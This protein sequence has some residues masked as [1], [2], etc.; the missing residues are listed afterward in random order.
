[1]GLT[2]AILVHCQVTLTDLDIAAELVEAN[3][4]ANR[5]EFYAESEAEF[6]VLK[7]A[8]NPNWLTHYNLIV[9]GDCTY[10]PNS[11]NDLLLT[12]N[13]VCSPES[14]LL[15]ASKERH[16]SEKAFDLMLQS[17]GFK[18]ARRSAVTLENEAETNNETVNITTLYRSQ[19]PK[20]FRD[21]PLSKCF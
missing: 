7:W 17:S 5:G 2:L 20:W 10:N 11:A 21:H 16:D 3:I 8:S 18:V 1:V 15:L 9:V 13:Q 19:T 12:L 14:V 6:K 4:K